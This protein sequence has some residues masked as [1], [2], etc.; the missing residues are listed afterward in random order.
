MYSQLCITMTQNIVKNGVS[1]GRI[2][3]Y[4]SSSYVGCHLVSNYKE[5]DMIAMFAKTSG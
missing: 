1:S 2:I 3:I 5:L 4:T